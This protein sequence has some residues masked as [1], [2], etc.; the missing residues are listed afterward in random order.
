MT[1]ED[2]TARRRGRRPAGQD[3]RTALVDA[4]RTVF[5]DNGYERATV[6][7]I[8]ARA[9]V[10]AAMVNHW[11]GSKEG[12]FAQAVLELP[13]EPVELVAALRDGPIEQFGERV[14]R[15]FITRWDGAGGDT[16][17][18]LVRSITSH[19]AASTVLRDFFSKFFAE[20]ITGLGSD[21]GPLR[22][23]LCASQLVG[24]GMIR[25]IARFEP[26][27]TTEVETLV[28]AIAP[29]LQR[30]LTGDLGLG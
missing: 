17:Q 14:V 23:T 28:T 5:A 7:A 1:T 4:A 26:L 21:N 29:T 2:S 12:L 25:Y 30:Y 3:T 15:T 20:L 27:A 24:L 22:T 8:A 10:D 11:F 19:E 13:F 6:R 16:F 9:G 18:A